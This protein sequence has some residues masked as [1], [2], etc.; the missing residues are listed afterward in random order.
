MTKRLDLDVIEYCNATFIVIILILIIGGLFVGAYY[1][2]NEQINSIFLAI[3]FSLFGVLFTVL[4]VNFSNSKQK[5]DSKKSYLNL[6]FPVLQRLLS[7][8]FIDLTHLVNFPKRGIKTKTYIDILRNRDSLVLNDEYLAYYKNNINNDELFLGFRDRLVD[9]TSINSIYLS[10]EFL[11][12]LTKIV[13]RLHSLALYIKLNDDKR[14]LKNIKAI[15]LHLQQI[16]KLKKLAF[17]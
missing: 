17:R 10:P 4:F 2:N 9:F 16:D 14:V 3:S 1:A 5:I 8:I 7:Y 15:F 11:I 6:I 12:A 13:E